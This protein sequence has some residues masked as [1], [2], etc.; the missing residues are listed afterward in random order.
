MAAQFSLSLPVNVQ[1]L[2]CF[3]FC[4]VTNTFDLMISCLNILHR[5]TRL[6]LST[7][8]VIKFSMCP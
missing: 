3:A 7:I 2:S 8:N 6:L 4:I 1:I 5:L